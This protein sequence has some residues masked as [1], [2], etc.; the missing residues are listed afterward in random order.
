MP[1]I[2][3]ARIRPAT[4]DVY[5]TP[6]EE[7][8]AGAVPAPPDP[9]AAATTAEIGY[10]WDNTRV[11]GGPTGPTGSTGP[12][13]PGST[14]EGPTGP[15]GLL[16][17]TGWTGPTG[18]FGETRDIVYGPTAPVDPN[19]V[20]IDDSDETT[21]WEDQSLLDEIT[22]QVSQLSDTVDG[23]YAVLTTSM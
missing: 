6:D 16:G 13:G 11:I 2:D 23:M 10:T 4:G 14:I 17:P 15:I 18:P 9:T 19:S 1:K 22:H 21:E 7:Q 12:T 8:S 5:F 3:Q 20:W